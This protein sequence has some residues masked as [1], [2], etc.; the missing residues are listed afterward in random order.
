MEN[1]ISERPAFAWWVKFVLW[2]RDDIILKTQRYWLKTHK[3]GIRVP[4]TVEETIIIDKENWYTLWWDEIIKEM[5]N[6][7][8]TSVVFERRK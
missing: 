3:Y 4:R 5:K 8:P 7:W 2:K 6:V 1:I